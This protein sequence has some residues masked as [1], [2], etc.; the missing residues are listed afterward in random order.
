MDPASIII[1]II[2]LTLIGLWHSYMFNIF[3]NSATI[4]IGRKPTRAELRDKH[5]AELEADL[6]IEWDKQFEPFM[7]KPKPVYFGSMADRYEQ[8]RSFEEVEFKRKARQYMD[9]LNKDFEVRRVF[10]ERLYRYEDHIYGV[11]AVGQRI[12]MRVDT[13]HEDDYHYF[14]DQMQDAVMVKKPM[15]PIPTKRTYDAG[16]R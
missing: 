10:N 11:N 15:P 13:L 12:G 2:V 7:P 9:G 1:L 14:V 16:F 8:K 3:D 6:G 4:S 5:I